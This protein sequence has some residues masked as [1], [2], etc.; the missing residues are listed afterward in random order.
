MPIALA[1][2]VDYEV[3]WCIL[4]LADILVWPVEETPL[5]IRL[6]VPPTPVLKVPP[7]LPL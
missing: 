3:Q 5:T 4:K 6:R 7:S 1:P 2:D